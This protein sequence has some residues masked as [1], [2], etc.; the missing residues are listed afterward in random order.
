MVVVFLLLLL[1]FCFLTNGKKC[2][3]KLYGG[4]WGEKKEKGK[5]DRGREKKI[6]G[7][8]R[9]KIK[10]TA[11]N[12]IFSR[13]KIRC[14]RAYLNCTDIFRKDNIENVNRKKERNNDVT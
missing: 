11:Q 1:L 5:E 12:N 6:I 7:R 3:Y 14:P 13:L 4:T 10:R 2:D 8:T 9:K